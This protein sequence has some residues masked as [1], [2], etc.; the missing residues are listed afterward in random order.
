MA[1]DPATWN[2]GP[3][4]VHSTYAA[5]SVSI[6]TEGLKRVLR[7]LNDLGILMQKDV[8]AFATELDRRIA[9]KTPVDT[10]RARASWHVVPP[11]TESDQFSYQD[12]HGKTFDG[13]LA[14]ASTGPMEAIVGT[15]VNYMLY[16]EAGHSRQAPQGMIALSLQELHGAL[17]NMILDTVNKAVKGG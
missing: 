11:G 4:Q 9:M 13:S 12:L 6:E 15:N 8:L 3:D 2:Y 14:G 17:H 16:L 7:T 5:G 1:T 10:G